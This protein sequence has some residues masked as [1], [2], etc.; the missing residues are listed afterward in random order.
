MWEEDAD[1]HVP[2]KGDADSTADVSQLILVTASML[3]L[4]AT[5][6][7]QTTLDAG[8][9]Q[10]QQPAVAVLSTALGQV[11]LLKDSLIIVGN[12]SSSEHY[13]DSLTA[14]VPHSCATAAAAAAAP[15]ND[16][17]DAGDASSYSAYEMM[18]PDMMSG[19]FMVSSSNHWRPGDNYSTV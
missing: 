7:N 19:A 17:C 9:E 3:V 5:A 1:V 11:V 6:D 10:V 4:P 16:A 14:A 8:M 2:V 15:A 13:A 18:L 12:S